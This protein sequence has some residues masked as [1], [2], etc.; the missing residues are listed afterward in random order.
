M[1]K[2][3]II[4]IL[5]MLFTMVGCAS[6]AETPTHTT[7]NDD[8]QQGIEDMDRP[9]E[10]DNEIDDVT[11]HGTWE[12]D[13]MPQD[14]KSLTTV[15]FDDFLYPERLLREGLPQNAEKIEL[16]NAGGA[17]K[18]E[19]IFD[20][21]MTFREIGACT[22]FFGQYGVEFDLYPSMSA[23]GNEIY[24]T[25][26]EEVGYD[27]AYGIID[28]DAYVLRDETNNSTIV[29]GPFYQIEGTQ[30]GWGSITNA[31]GQI[32]SFLLVRP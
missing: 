6:T 4:L 19:L 16:Y 30:F 17:W 29:L 21:D 22:L 20:T 13:L 26:R 5:V 9:N 32:G 14:L 31:E 2:L 1:K 8:I 7:D 27:T 11:G 24:E 18:Y 23:W 10:H 15:I 3:S 28:G 12:E 25:S